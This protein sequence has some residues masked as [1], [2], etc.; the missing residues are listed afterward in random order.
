MTE[1][2]RLE[3][4]YDI[5]NC[6]NYVFRLI[7]RLEDDLKGEEKTIAP[8]TK[9]ENLNI[10]LRTKNVLLRA[11]F[12]EVGD[13]QNQ[14]RVSLMRLRNMGE[15]SAEETLAV[16]EQAGIKVESGRELLLRE[17]KEEES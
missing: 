10:P 4:L 5:E 8:S 13:L 3:A 1:R 7:S 17:A 12:R 6:L 11:G 16:M 14:S 2:A 9:I 15:K